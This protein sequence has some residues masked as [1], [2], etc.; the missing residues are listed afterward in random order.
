MKPQATKGLRVYFHVKENNSP[1]PNI[2]NPGMSPDHVR[3]ILMGYNVKLQD[4]DEQ[5]VSEDGG[6]V[7]GINNLSGDDA[8][9]DYYDLQGRRVATPRHGVY[10][11]DGKK[12]VVK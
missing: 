11:Q 4:D 10:I 5:F 3:S 7:D 1:D 6:F 12:R 2:G 9:G 8:Q